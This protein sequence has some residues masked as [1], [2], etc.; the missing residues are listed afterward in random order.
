MSEPLYNVKEIIE[1]QFNT[2]R[3]DLRE[4]KETLRDQNIQTEKRFTKIEKE[5]DDI[6]LE[7]KAQSIVQARYNIVWSVGVF[8]GAA[9]ITIFLNRYL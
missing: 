8:I 2:L 6:R 5:L 7:Q 1:L 4:I 3:N 9:V